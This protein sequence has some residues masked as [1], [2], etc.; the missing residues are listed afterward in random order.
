MSS[1]TRQC[2]AQILRPVG[3][4]LAERTDMSRVSVVVHAMMP[5]LLR[6]L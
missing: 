2:V 1:Q 4:L 6:D 5:L 3:G